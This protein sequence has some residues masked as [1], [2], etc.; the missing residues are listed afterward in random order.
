MK[1]HTCTRLLSLVLAVVMMLSLLSVA[2][3][4]AGAPDYA[5]LEI[6]T[7]NGAPGD[8]VKIPVYLKGLKEGRE[9]GASEARKAIASALKASGMD[10]AQIA[11]I[12]G[13]DIATINSL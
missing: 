6:G 7:A 2:A 1:Y 13:L 5:H 4:A 3:F 10:V 11:Q 9:E 8:T 12:T